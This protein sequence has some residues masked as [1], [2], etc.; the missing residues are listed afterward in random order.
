MS[1]IVSNRPLLIKRSF[2]NSRF[3]TSI[4][5][6]YIGPENKEIN[7]NERGIGTS[8]ITIFAENGQTT[9]ID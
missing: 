8:Q 7:D 9:M 6:I 2:V 5:C 4:V 1:L 3:L